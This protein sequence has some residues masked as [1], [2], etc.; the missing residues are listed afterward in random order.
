[1]SLISFETQEEEAA[2]SRWFQSNTGIGFY[3]IVKNNTFLLSAEYIAFP[4]WTAGNRK[5][6]DERWFW[7]TTGV[8]IT[9][10]NWAESFPQLEISQ[11]ACILFS[12]PVRG[13]QDYL[14]EIPAPNSPGLLCE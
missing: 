12:V 10:F 9:E 8:D 2:V 6:Q 14:C 7:S 3:L 4:I 5:A 1:M 13:W 11:H